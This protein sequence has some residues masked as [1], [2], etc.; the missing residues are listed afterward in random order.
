MAASQHLDERDHPRLGGAVRIDERAELP[1]ELQHPGQ[2]VALHKAEEMPGLGIH[3]GKAMV[4]RPLQRVEDLVHGRPHGQAAD[5]RRHAVFRLQHEHVLL[6]PVLQQ[7]NRAQVDV[8]IV[9][10]LAEQVAGPLREHDRRENWDAPLGLACRLHEYDGQGDGNPSHAGEHG[11]RADERVHPRIATDDAGL[12]DGLAQDPAER[13]SA[14]QRG[15]E[16]AARDAKPVR[17]HRLRKV[18]ERKNEQHAIIQVVLAVEEPVD[19]VAPEVDKQPLPD[20]EFL[21]VRRAA[22]HQR[23][24]EIEGHDR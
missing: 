23:H 1:V 7:R 19:G 8:D 15:H 10:A 17:Q 3:Y 12:V 4:P 14:K 20:V 16:K 5:L 18:G 6:R 9:D 22:I 21:H 13:S 11:R 2:R 24:E